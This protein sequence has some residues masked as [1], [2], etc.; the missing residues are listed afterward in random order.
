MVDN[1]SVQRLIDRHLVKIENSDFI[2]RESKMK[3]KD[4]HVKSKRVVSLN[5]Q[6]YY[7]NRIWVMCRDHFPNK[8]IT[9]LTQHDIEVFE[10]NIKNSDYKEN[11]KHSFRVAI[12][13]F[14]QIVNG[15]AWNSKKYPIIV[16]NL[17]LTKNGR[18][19]AGE[20]GSTVKASDILSVD[21]IA[22]MTE[23]ALN[24]RDKAMIQVAFETSAR[25]DE[26]LSV[27][28]KDVTFD[29]NGGVIVL[30]GY[31]RA[32]TPIPILFSVPF[33]K[34]WISE[35]SHKDDNNSALW[36]SV[37]NVEKR[38]PIT[39]KYYNKMLKRCAKRANI[40]KR[41]WAYLFRHSGITHQ[42]KQGLSGELLCIYSGWVLGSSQVKTYAHL[43]GSDLRNKMLQINNILPENPDKIEPPKAVMCPRC[44]Y[45]NN[46]K[47]DYCL[48][49]DM[50]LSHKAQRSAIE[51]RQ[52]QEKSILDMITP[53]MVEQMIQKRV[54]EMIKSKT[55]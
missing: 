54:D 8:D 11:T 30:S 26:L 46:D 19:K 24:V 4:F 47:I 32:P 27:K 28:I 45:E 13:K 14:L 52:K 34:K 5:R 50:A 38:E 43:T 12:K 15:F 16:E 41:I 49:C 55:L 29:S 21:E 40:D 2:T 20:S 7:L 48:R 17:K 9:K 37:C 53:E 42:V 6:L 33:L 31:K 25:P 3:I 1:A 51:K 44:E 23:H 36:E 10:G 39:S 22:K 35:H 18:K